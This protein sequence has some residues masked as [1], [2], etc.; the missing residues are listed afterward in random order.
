V[1]RVLDVVDL[2]EDDDAFAASVVYEKVRAR[3][4]ANE[5]VRQ[6]SGT[7]LKRKF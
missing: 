5:Q 2:T 7:G 4:E 3:K 1:N 6:V